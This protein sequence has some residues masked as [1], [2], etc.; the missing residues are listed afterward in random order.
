MYVGRIARNTT[1]FFL[2]QRFRKFGQIDNV[3]LYF[4]R[5]K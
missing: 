4:R 5:Q 2:R 3:E 1:K